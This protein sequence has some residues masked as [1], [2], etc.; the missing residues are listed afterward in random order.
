MD[1]EKSKH[2]PGPRATCLVLLLVLGSGC[3]HD[4]TRQSW[5]AS[6]QPDSAGGDLGTGDGGLD[7][8]PG[9]D[10]HLLDLVA[11]LPVIHDLLADGVA[12]LP[13]TGADLLLPVDAPFDLAPPADTVAWPDSGPLCGNGKLDK[14]EQCDGKLLGGQTCKTKSFSGGVLKCKSCVFDATGCQQVLDPG[15]KMI[16]ATTGDDRYVSVGH[17]QRHLRGQDLVYRDNHHRD[18]DGHRNLHAQGH[19]AVPRGGLHQQ[20]MPGGMAGLSLQ[21]ELRYLRCAGAIARRGYRQVSLK[22]PG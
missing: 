22:W 19:P 20:L 15:G 6:T 21:Q 5:E 3:P 14:G 2:T 16:S 11:D 7:A 1:F 10:K 12:P 13:E 4:V 8:A 9:V 18:Q 17:Q